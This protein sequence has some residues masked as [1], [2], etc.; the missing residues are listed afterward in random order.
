MTLCLTMHE[1]KKRKK[2]N[3]FHVQLISENRQI[4]MKLIMIHVL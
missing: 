3:E 4:D 1:C 2:K